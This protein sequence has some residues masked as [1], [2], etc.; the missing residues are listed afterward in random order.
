[1]EVLN[2]ITTTSLLL[3]FLLPVIITLIVFF[4]QAVG[5]RGFG[6]DVPLLLSYSFIIIGP[7]FGIILLI[8]SLVLSNAFYYFFKNTKL[9]HLPKVGLIIILTSF[10]IGLLGILFPYYLINISLSGILAVIFI[11]SLTERFFSL[12]THTSVWEN[13]VYIVTISFIAIIAYLLFSIE[14]LRAIILAYPLFVLVFCVI[15]VL[16]LGNW[17]GLR[18]AEYYRFKEVA[19]NK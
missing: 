8:V 3:I 17:S 1:M 6:I 14:A 10:C 9:L 5:L 18:I 16:L 19:K 12:R 2:T 15:A 13:I 11:L 7:I 4:R